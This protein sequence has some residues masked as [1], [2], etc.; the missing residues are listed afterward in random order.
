MRIALSVDADFFNSCKMLSEDTETL[1]KFGIKETLSIINTRTEST[2]FEKIKEGNVDAFIL[3]ERLYTKKAIDF[4]KKKQ[5]YVPIVLVFE[6]CYQY[7]GGDIYMP[8][9]PTNVG[10]LRMLKN[11]YTYKKNFKKLY[12]ITTKSNSIL[13]RGKFKYDPLRRFFYVDDNLVKKFSPKEGGVFEILFKNFD[14]VVKKEIIL[15]SVWKENS[16]FNGR[17]LDVYVTHLRKALREHTDL[18]IRNISGSGF[19]LENT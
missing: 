1:S 12:D 3:D 6:K 10:F 13:K 14:E 5:P 18:V 4:I 9:E 19:I 7:F 8:W 17:S 11:I 2:L 16:Y 15:E